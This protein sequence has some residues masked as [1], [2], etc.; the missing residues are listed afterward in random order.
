MVVRPSGW[1]Y[2]FASD[3]NNQ[4]V[5]F[6]NIVVSHKRGPVV[7]QLVY[8]ALGLQAPGISIHANNGLTYAPPGESPTIK[9]GKSDVYKNTY[10]RP[11]GFDW[12]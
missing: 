11:E 12:Y 7:E 1:V 9:Y 8:Y 4:N 5:F 10:D 2:V 6:D 3:E